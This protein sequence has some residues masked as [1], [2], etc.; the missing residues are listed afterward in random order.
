MK[1]M[2]HHV[3]VSAALFASLLSLGISPAYAEEG[4]PSTAPVVT[5]NGEPTSIRTEMIDGK[6]YFSL[7]DYWV[8]GEGISPTSIT[9]FAEDQTVSNGSN[10]LFLQNQTYR[11]TN[12]N[13]TPL[14]DPAVLKNGTTYV[15]SSFL[16]NSDCY[17]QHSIIVEE[18]ENSINFKAT[19]WERKDG[20]P[21][22]Y[23]LPIIF[24]D[25]KTG[26]PAFETVEGIRMAGF[27]ND[28][29]HITKTSTD[30][31]KTVFQYV[32][33]EDPSKNA[34]VTVLG[35]YVSHVVDDN[36]FFRYLIRA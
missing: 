29:Y 26:L 20:Y 5:I 33:K 31:G 3:G 36:G 25:E 13:I 14:T 11:N 15:A 28:A 9:W 2:L 4:A 24:L 1:K 32:L 17:K 7:R 10:F 18:N 16:Q 30:D 12:G 21:M 8:E 22:D 23:R 35:D 6:L 27:T 34:T 19:L